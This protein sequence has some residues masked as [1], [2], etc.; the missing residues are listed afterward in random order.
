MIKITLKI[1]LFLV[2]SF[3]ITSF[4]NI[5][6]EHYII[7]I[8]C[9][10]NIILFGI[11]KSNLTNHV[12]TNVYD[13]N[14]L[15]AHEWVLN[16]SKGYKVT[17]IYDEIADSWTVRHSRTQENLDGYK[18]NRIKDEIDFNIANVDRRFTPYD[19]SSS[20]G[21]K[22][23]DRQPNVGK[24]MEIKNKMKVIRQTRK[25]NLTT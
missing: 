25:R 6:Y 4:F 5:S 1:I 12:S 18:G 9:I 22:S 24:M 3:L 11:L 7:F 23:K 13:K 17:T 20:N 19:L 14:G 10:S 2:A 21:G 15:L 8:L 16:Y